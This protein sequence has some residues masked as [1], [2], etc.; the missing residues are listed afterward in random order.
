M[1]EKQ[2]SVQFSSKTVVDR[3]FH[4][5][6]HLSMFWKD[7]G[8]SSVSECPWLVRI[9]MRGWSS[10]QKPKSVESLLSFQRVENSKHVVWLLRNLW[11][12]KS[13]NLDVSHSP[14]FLFHHIPLSFCSYLFLPLWGW[15]IQWNI[16]KPC[17]VFDVFWIFFLLLMLP[18]EF[19]RRSYIR[20]GADH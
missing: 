13:R 17:S 4:P 2:H 9:L 5:S 8:P 11:L 10:A 18:H 3:I 1:E 14:L 16:N 6:T 19:C 7:L 15:D 12:I 20:K